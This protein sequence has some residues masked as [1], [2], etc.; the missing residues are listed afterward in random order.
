MMLLAHLW[1]STICAGVAT[2]LVAGLRQAPGRVRHR[3]WLCASLK[4]LL[5]FGVLAAAGRAIGVWLPATAAPSASIT[6]R[7]LDRSGPFWNLDPL[8]TAGGS[9]GRPVPW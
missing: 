2:V 6:V 3:I 8:W 9:S 5:P 7:W 1:Q 4:F